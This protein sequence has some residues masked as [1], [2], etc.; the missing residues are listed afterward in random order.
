[1]LIPDLIDSGVEV[2]NPIQTSAA[3]MDPFKLKKE[4]GDKLIFHGAIDVQKVLPSDDPDV[5]RDEVKRVLDAMAPGGGYILAPSHNIQ[6]DIPPENI[7]A[8]FETALEYGKY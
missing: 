8:M 4:F 2:L 7:I 1:M 5:V 6:D 3:D